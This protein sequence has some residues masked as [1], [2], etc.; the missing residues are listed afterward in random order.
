MTQS[1]IPTCPD[2]GASDWTYDMRGTL[3]TACGTLRERVKPEGFVSLESML[4]DFRRKAELVPADIRAQLPEWYEVQLAAETALR[5]KVH[6]A[7]VRGV[8]RSVADGWPDGD[9]RYVQVWTLNAR[10]MWADMLVEDLRTRGHILACPNHGVRGVEVAPELYEPLS[11]LGMFDTPPLAASWACY[12]ETCSKSGWIAAQARR[13]A[14]GGR[15][16]MVVV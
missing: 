8:D 2:C 13:M 14:K 6:D 9:A 5:D 4:A 15:P 11:F 16:G 12:C 1:A 3:C 10:L 7:F